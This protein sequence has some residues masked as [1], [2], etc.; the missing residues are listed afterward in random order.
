M[1]FFPI[2]RSQSFGDVDSIPSPGEA[3]KLRTSKVDPVFSS[4][5]GI[6]IR[7]GTWPKPY[8]MRANCKT[9]IL[10]KRKFFQQGLLIKRC[11]FGAY[12]D[13]SIMIEKPQMNGANTEVSQVE[14]RSVTWHC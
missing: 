8:T 2:P 7:A 1:I 9:V 3:T 13:L 5:Q 10:G 4:D 6:A 11:Q 12:H 14:K